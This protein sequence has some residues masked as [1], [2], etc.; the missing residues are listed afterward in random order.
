M[1]DFLVFQLYGVLAAWGDIAVGEYRPS[2]GH[3]TKSAVTGLLGAAL[4]VDRSDE[5]Q[6]QQLTQQYGVAVCV[7]DFGELLR[8]F[9]TIQVPGGKHRSRSRRDE[10]CLDPL[11]LNTMLST[12]DYHNDA[13]YQVAVWPRND[14]VSYSLEM[15]K[16]HLQSPHF[17]LYLGRKSCPVGLPLFPVIS[18]NHTLQQAFESYPLEKA[19]NWIRMKP[20]PNELH[21]YWEDGLSTEELGN[22]KASMVYSRRDKIRSRRRW[23]FASRDEFYASN[24]SGG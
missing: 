23:Q 15:L 16:E 5:S 7:H 11:N 6:H 21:Y 17:T 8:D 14:N 24:Q 19:S 20:K 22:L 9:H 13:F 2:L 18:R 1:K 12:R 10:L 3:P 4:G